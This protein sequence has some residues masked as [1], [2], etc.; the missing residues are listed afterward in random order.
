MPR[1]DVGRTRQIRSQDRDGGSHLAGSGHRLHE[2]VQTPATLK[3]APSFGPFSRA[4]ASLDLLVVPST[5]ADATPRAVLESSPRVCR[6]WLSPRAAFPRSW[7][8]EST[9][10]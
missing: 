4:V 3:I 6:W 8:M 9:A 5:A 7:S 2:R 1:G 10:S